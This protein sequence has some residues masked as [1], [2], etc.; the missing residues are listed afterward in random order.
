LKLGRDCS[1]GVGEGVRTD[2]GIVP[3]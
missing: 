3:P 1:E 2:E